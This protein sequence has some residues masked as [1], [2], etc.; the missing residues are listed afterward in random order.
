[1]ALRFGILGTGNIARQFAGSFK[2]S[3]GCVVTAVG[4]RTREAAEAFVGQYA[5][6]AEATGYEG[7]LASKEVD[8]VYVS[9][10]NS[11]HHEWTIRALRA[12]KHVLCEKPLAMNAAEAE[13]MFAEAKKAGKL[14]VEAFMYVSH[15]LVSGPGG[16]LEVVRTGKIGRVRHVRTSFCYR[17][18]K[19]AG[20][21][22]FDAG[23]GGGALLDIGCYCV[24]FSRLMARAAGEGG[25]GEPVAIAAEGSFHAASGVDDQVA[26]LLRFSSGLTATFNCGMAVQADN[27]AT[28]S[29]EEGYLELPV[30]WKPPAVDA[31]MVL[32]RS[33]PP[34]QDGVPPAGTSVRPPPPL[35]EE[36]LFQAGKDLYALEADDFAAAVRGEKA[37]AVSE[38][39]S[40]GNVRVL[41][42]IRKLIE[43]GRA[44]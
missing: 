3:V 16:A 42:A 5:P 37:P 43:A 41:D 20:N 30:P 25:G 26:G 18:M 2:T 13:E 9:F 1:M 11:M 19:I 17:T 40:M 35:R 34:K 28:V 29:G 27:T 38:A 12:G 14:L 7:V 21:V 36:L 39:D 10:P 15:P 22:R 23:L 8:A 24:H 33:T 6:G 32:A 44:R 31:R 4:S